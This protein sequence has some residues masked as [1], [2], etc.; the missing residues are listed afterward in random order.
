VVEAEARIVADAGSA[1]T[2][3]VGERKHTQGHA[4]LWTERGHKGSL[5]LSFGIC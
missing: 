2:A 5:E 3:A 4:V 1:A